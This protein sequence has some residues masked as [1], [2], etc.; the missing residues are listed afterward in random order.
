MGPP[1]G[2]L[3]K[4][5]VV[6][7]GPPRGSY[8]FCTRNPSCFCPR[9]PTLFLGGGDSMG[10]RRAPTRFV[11]EPAGWDGPHMFCPRT[12][13]EMSPHMFCPRIPTLS[14]LTHMIISCLEKCPTFAVWALRLGGVV[15]QRLQQNPNP[16]RLVFSLLRRWGGVLKV[17]VVFQ[18]VV[19]GPPLCILLVP[20][21]PVYEIYL[22]TTQ[23]VSEEKLVDILERRRSLPIQ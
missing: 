21:K 20:K 3:I 4:C 10:M 22:P 1:V 6:R 15:F 19:P 12:P 16:G 17:G 5:S 11:T 13:G 23:V 8:H 14:K 2:G 7:S 9:A 18:K